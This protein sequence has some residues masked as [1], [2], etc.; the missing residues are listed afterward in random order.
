[1]ST[2]PF[3]ADNLVTALRTELAFIDTRL[4]DYQ[5]LIASLPSNM[6]YVLIDEGDGMQQM[7][8]ALTGRSGVDAIHVFS[9]GTSGQLQ[10]GNSLL[11][12]D[13][14][15]NYASPLS[16]IAGSLSADGDILLYGC[17]V[18]EGSVGSE[19]IGKLA[20]ATSADVA[21]STNLTGAADKGGDWVLETQ[22]GPIE[23]AS[24]GVENYAGILAPYTVKFTSGNSVTPM[25][26]YDSYFG[27]T[28]IPNVSI[29]FGVSNGSNYGN[30]CADSGD[31]AVGYIL[32]GSGGTTNQFL[33]NFFRIQT[34]SDAQDF[35][36]SS[37]VVRTMTA[38]S[39]V[40]HV[41]GYA[42]GSIDAATGLPTAGDSHVYSTDLT[43]PQGSNSTIDLTGWNNISSLVI[44]YTDG[45]KL[46]FGNF[47]FSDIVVNA[48]P[49]LGGTFTT[50]GTV[51]DNATTTPFTGVTY[52][53]SD[54]SN[55]AYKV[56]IT[57]TAANGTLSGTGVTGSNGSYTVT[58]TDATDVASKLHAVIFTPTANQ[59][60][61]GSTVQTT[62]TLTPND[63]IADGTADS[64]TKVTA[65]SI[66]DA[67]V[68]TA[69][70]VLAT[71]D[72]PYT[73]AAANFGFT[74][75]DPSSALASVEIVGLPAKGT[76]SLSGTPIT[77]N[78][79]I[80]AANIP[81]LTWTPNA[82]EYGTSNTSLTF[83]VNDGTL[84]DTTAR[85]LTF[86]VTGVADTPSIT[87]AQTS[88]LT[89]TTSGLVIS[90]N[91]ADDAEV[92]NFKITG[93]TGGTLYQSN[94]STAITNGDFI[95][96][97][98]ANAGLKFTPTAGTI[99]GH[100]TVQAATA[101]N[102]GALGGSSI[103]A[104][105][106]VNVPPTSTNDS[107][108]TLEDTT[109]VLASTDF[110]TY[111][112]SE[113]D[114][115]TSVQITTLPATGTLEYNGG[116]WT[117][118]TLNQVISKADIDA[119]KL[120]FTPGTDL[121]G[122][123]QV[124]LGFK[125][126]DSNSYST[127]PYTL[128]F[129][130]TAVNDA[131]VGVNDTLTITE[132]GGAANGGNGSNG[133]GGNSFT[134]NVISNDTDV[135]MGATRTITAIRTGSTEGAGTA[136]TIG[137]ALAGT[138]GEL[139]QNSDGTYS[140]ALDNTNTNVQALLA[141]GAT[142]SE[143]YNYTVTDD[144][145]ATDTALLTLTINGANDYTAATGVPASVTVIE[146]VASNVDL[147]AVTL[148][149][150]DHASTTFKLVASE[151]TLAA[152]SAGG[153]TVTGSGTA[154]LTLAGTTAA[155]NTFLD[156]VSNVQ[157][158]SAAND[159]GTPGATI[160]LSAN[161]GVSGY[162]SLGSIN[163]NITPVNDAPAGAINTVTI[164]EDTTH[165]FT[166]ANFGFSDATDNVPPSSGNTLLTVKIT[167][168]PSVGTGTL[169]LD[170]NTL[171]AGAVVALSDINA[172]KLV[173]T[174]VSNASGNAAA[175]FT[176]QV[177]DNGGTDNNGVDL[178]TTPRTL[179]INLTPANDAPV[180]V[181]GVPTL[182]SITEEE[183]TNS[184][185]LISTLVGGTSGGAVTGDKSGIT[186]VDTL[187]NS[188]SGF[189][190]EFV[191]QGVAI[192]ATA[193]NGPADGGTWQYKLASGGGWVNFASAGAITATSALL[194][195]STDSVRFVPDQLNGTTATFS[196]YLW[197]GASGGIAARANVS[198]RGGAT[199]FSTAS[200]VATITVSPVNDAPVLDL[201]A[202]NSSTATGDSTGGGVSYKGNFLVRGSGVAVL[203]TDVRI[204]DVD[205]S[206]T[207]GATTPDTIA[208]ATVAIT[209]GA[210]DNI[211]TV[212][213][214]LTASG[215]NGTAGGLTVS[216]SGTASISITGTGTWAQ[217]E[218]LLKTI[219]YQ[220][221]NPD[222]FAGVRT[223]SV[224][225]NDSAAP[226]GTAGSALATTSIN[227]IWAPV[228][229]TNGSLAGATFTTTY[230]DGGAPVAIA[231]NSTITD[232]DSN[233]N[234]VVVS[235]SN[236]QNAGQE[237]LTITGG[238]GANWNGTGLTVAGSGTTSVT[239]SGNT[240]ASFYQ[241]AL[242]SIKYANSSGSPSEVQRDIT[243][244]ATDIDNHVGNTGHSY[245][246]VVSVPNAPT[247]AN[248][249]PNQS[250]TGSGNKTFQFAA[251]TFADSDGDTLTYTV[252]LADDTALPTWLN[253]DSATRT[254]SGN[255]PHG[256]GPLSVK[257]TALDGTSNAGVPRSGS[258]TF[259]WTF[260]TPNDAPT[261][262]NALVDQTHSGS[263]NITPYTFAANS[264]ADADPGETFT[265][266]AGL[267][268]GTTLSALPG[269]L[270]FNTSTRSFSGNP[271]AGTTS[272]LT[273]RVT[274][275]D[276]G[277]GTVTDDF[278]LTLSGNLNDIGGLP[279][280]AQAAAVTTGVVAQLNDF[281]VTDE[282]NSTQTFRVTLTP[283]NGSIGGLTDLDAN[284]PG[285]QLSG[286]AAQLNTAIAA[287]TFTAT[288]AG[289]ASIAIEVTDSAS[290]PNVSNAT[291]N[292]V[293]SALPS[294]TTPPVFQSAAT[295]SAGTQVILA[296]DGALNATTAAAGA[297]SVTTGGSGNAVTGVMISGSTVVLTLATAI[298]NGQA[299]TL[300]YTDPSASNDTNAIQ[301][302]AGNDA[303]SLSST[304]VTNNVAAN[305]GGTTGGSTT[306]SGTTGGE[307]TG[308]GTS[309]GGGT[310]TGGT[311][312][313]VNG[314]TTTTTTTGTTTVTDPTTGQTTTVSTQTTLTTV[315]IITPPSQE[316]GGTT[317]NA[318]IPLATN[319][320]GETLVQTS[321]PTGVG[322][323]SEAVTSGSSTG[324]AHL[325]L[326]ELLIASVEP[327]SDAPTFV[328]ILDQIDTYVPS[329]R[330]EAQ[331]TV[332]TI[333]FQ[334]SNALTTAPTAPVVI[335]GA[336][337]TGELDAAHPDRQEAL[338]IDARNLP[339]GTVL[340]LDNVEF[341]IIIGA[342]RVTG[343]NGQN[344]AIGDNAAQYIVLGADNDN[345]HGGGGNDTV[346][347]KGG[348][349]SLYGDDGDD[350]VV[351]GIGNDTLYGGDGNDVLQG[352]GSDAGNWTIALDKSGMMHL[353]Y[354][355]SDTNLATMVT[356]GTVWNWSQ[357]AGARG[358]IDSRVSILEQDYTRLADFALLY[359]AVTGERPD[360]A[361][362]ESTAANNAFTTDS[363]ARIAYDY[364]LAQH[365]SLGAQ[366]LEVQVKA[367]IEQ[368]W[369]SATTAQV[370]AGV[371]YLQNG[372]TWGEAFKLL[373]LNE[374]S[375][376][377]LADSAGNLQLTKAFALGE[378]GWAAGSG[379]D[380][381]YGGNGNDRLV[382]G[383]GANLLDGGAGI[384]LASFVGTINDYQL[385]LRETSSGAMDLVIRNI[386]SGEESILRNVELASF[387]DQVYQAKA[388]QPSLALN[389]FTAASACLELVGTTQLQAMGVPAGWL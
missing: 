74:D 236:V 45:I 11:S 204:T 332:R 5:T 186:D 317:P 100:I 238:N 86:N 112:D 327:R 377:L 356:A 106:L 379:N 89:Q 360:A 197:D 132:A 264:F 108:T 164:N 291:Y 113:G 135:D 279:D 9:H 282:V 232:Q 152:A 277:G 267:W 255:P 76:V 314:V 149:D 272:P 281:T 385:G 78:Q 250:S 336:T 4:A 37:L 99:T 214:T 380:Q 362:L 111:A 134:G 123:A 229:D 154:T 305:N 213:E 15:S 41:K 321:V 247:V 190:G 43:L 23:S 198:V 46:G 125:V 295:N 70:S 79:V 151:G 35:S 157:Y 90:R 1:M 206:G 256:A 68:G 296:Y 137:Q 189:A 29:A 319:S 228:V 366:A 146:D 316:G 52:S 83:K 119:G 216:G 300:T 8:D 364:Y 115:F 217:Y 372:G 293:A 378:V 286:T 169:T 225:L 50:A 257:V 346:G 145:G 261:L 24:I 373:A 221:A 258:S 80:S 243:V 44:D 245:I 381:L 183:T 371:T 16:A 150:A 156:T 148:S 219:T 56:N 162:Q 347:S 333:T 218:T 25:T 265:Y 322:L 386:A 48:A 384:D 94:G 326:R 248:A 297:F 280:P 325:G 75:V 63:G 249:I 205:K 309:T 187:N 199:A 98:Q 175:S 65:T 253:F 174:P 367:L 177:Q 141:N 130:V 338:V 104:D 266:S 220:N 161:D 172:N 231:N 310:T 128:T 84:A 61:V 383:G 97:A 302:A 6:E 358:Q 284:T 270:S 17:N 110:G 375:R 42:S 260:N 21:A 344:V 173:Y 329:V 237:T 209:A 191:G 306:G 57:F 203:D 345:L 26:V 87:N 136:G 176:F 181:D 92:A 118:V 359:H 142:L 215:G 159:Y 27:S 374:T 165:T 107:A 14:L 200:D 54:A 376:S 153:V 122:A 320:Q 365:T 192:F 289:A 77:A 124:S 140:Y 331:V 315:P 195:G 235:I 60:A 158:T 337:G 66:N 299:V 340:R 363:L 224:T 179:T 39:E 273:V 139:T 2:P 96:F 22:T 73:F 129:N 304:W 292:L 308:S 32:M 38:S 369:G 91:A 168:L 138:Y 343:G 276:S 278:T 368:V 178:D 370:Q 10:L 18:A 196:Y 210:F 163:V 339:S 239:I 7:A 222:A 3:N 223:V 262:A 59:V 126:N 335:N 389:S 269:W 387:G 318:Y 357:P 171:T 184:G 349:D 251:N 85:T 109:I 193:N 33:G 155:I 102:D 226:G 294:D 227:N 81:N 71:E 328:D 103:T 67:P 208:S 88:P 351:G 131:P 283:T 354:A 382:G 301:D 312:T 69:G 259:T 212:N 82:N 167:T 121:N 160:A 303:S 185:N 244:V 388:L 13:T 49:V 51:N 182:N 355:A 31:A 334:A 211:S 323:T 348:N 133:T 12:S 246:N 240:A 361:W 353:D 311:S 28:N 234:Q 275:T 166:A 271:P 233:L 263:G 180:L 285:I 40:I 93:I 62:F 241:L 34:G 307:S 324:G 53:D 252:S 330:D 350:F 72:T 242:N 19:F 254:F 114:P 117:A 194:L 230:T 47:V 170:G 30:Y 144:Q 20:Q 274:A 341:T 55:T 268:N 288:A 290:T 105:I 64:T 352:G 95:T 147:S 313:T 202:N 116:S 127:S 58:G 287:A 36:I 298:T 188:G 143:I 120:R 207:S 201:D 342:T 101:A